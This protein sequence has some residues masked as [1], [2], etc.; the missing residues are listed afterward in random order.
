MSEGFRPLRTPSMVTGPA[1]ALVSHCQRHGRAAM[2]FAVAEMPGGKKQG[3]SP[4]A[5]SCTLKALGVLAGD[6][7]DKT[8]F[9]GVSGSEEVAHEK[10]N[11][12]V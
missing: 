4:A 10:A 1:A 9:P 2:C 12:Y 5:F 8:C 6:V 11:L 3:G 7:L